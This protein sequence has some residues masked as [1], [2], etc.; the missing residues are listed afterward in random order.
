M[1]KS[2]VFFTDKYED[3]KM[4]ISNC[5]IELSTAPVTQWFLDYGGG[6]GEAEWKGKRNV[7]SMFIGSL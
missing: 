1:E 3:G 7:S 2:K 4:E 5:A 6:R